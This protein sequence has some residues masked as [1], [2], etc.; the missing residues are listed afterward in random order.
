MHNFIIIP[1]KEY[2]FIQ[3][4]LL[5]DLDPP[6]P[7]QIPP[8]LLAG[9]LHYNFISKN[10]Q[11]LPNVSKE[12]N[13]ITLVVV[14]KN[15]YYVGLTYDDTLWAPKI[16]MKGSD[17]SF[18]KKYCKENYIQIVYNDS[19]A[20]QLS[21]IN[22]YEFIPEDTF[23]EVAYIIVKPLRK[24]SD[25]DVLYVYRKKLVVGLKKEDDQYHI[26]LK[27]RN[28]IQNV[29]DECRKKKVLIRYH[30]KITE[31]LYYNYKIND[32]FEVTTE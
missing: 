25:L 30:K 11:T 1:D 29:I 10:Y 14:Y 28:K 15:K 3:K 21:K 26:I 9:S 27:A 22:N 2:R 17:V 6:I 18:I 12:L 7:M 31:I 4:P 24:I 23:E 19:L 16:L 20:E 13:E 8:Y 5:T 32:T